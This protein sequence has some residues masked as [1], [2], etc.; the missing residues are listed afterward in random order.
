MNKLFNISLSWLRSHQNKFCSLC[1]CFVP[2]RNLYVQ[3]SKVTFNIDFTWAQ[4]ATRLSSLLLKA[5]AS[6]PRI[7]WPC[8]IPQGEARVI[9]GRILHTYCGCENKPLAW[10][11]SPCGFHA[12]FTCPMSGNQSRNPQPQLMIQGPG[13]NPNTVT[14]EPIH[15]QLNT[16]WSWHSVEWPQNCWVVINSYQTY[17]WLWGKEISHP[18][19]LRA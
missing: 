4:S 2:Q 9:I 16:F 15:S 18:L 1:S 14:G 7:T 10:L 12:C 11:L 3:L 17:W 13:S 6:L 8:W 5:I 19:P